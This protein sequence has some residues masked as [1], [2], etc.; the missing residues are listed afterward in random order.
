MM[1]VDYDMRAPARF[2]AALN[3]QVVDKIDIALRN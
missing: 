2:N 3:H 1:A